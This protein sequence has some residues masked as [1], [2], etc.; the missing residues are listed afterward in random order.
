MSCLKCKS[1]HECDW[2][3]E[4]KGLMKTTGSGVIK[5]P[6]LPFR[7]LFVSLAGV[8]GPGCARERV[9]REE[10]RG[11]EIVCHLRTTNGRFTLLHY[12]F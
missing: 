8:G 4:G 10:L 3:L 2:T 11:S 9:E 1:R 6:R 7:A 5:G 12:I